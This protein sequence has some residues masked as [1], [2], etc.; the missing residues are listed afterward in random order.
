MPWGEEAVHHTIN[1]IQAQL[2]I[3]KLVKKH[4]GLLI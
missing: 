2:I 1:A 4:I 3:F